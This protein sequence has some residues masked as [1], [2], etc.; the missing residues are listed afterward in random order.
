M[1]SESASA[2]VD[3]AKDLAKYGNIIVGFAVA[4][5]LFLAYALGKQ[6]ELGENIL[7]KRSSSVKQATFV[8]N[9]CYA[10]SIVFFGLGEMR[11]RAA[12]HQPHM[13]LSTTIAIIG[14]RLLTLA[15]AFAIAYTALRSTESPPNSG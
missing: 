1:S 13:I 8:M 2:L 6:D 15:L 14:A 4:Q 10:L 7:K 5:A 12:A 3:F 11:F 9:G